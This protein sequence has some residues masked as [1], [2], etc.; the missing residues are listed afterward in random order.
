MPC[1]G[2][3]TAEEDARELQDASRAAC[4]LARALRKRFPKVWDELQDHLHPA[5]IEWVAEHDKAD[6]KREVEEKRE[7]ERRDLAQ[8]ARAKLSKREREALGIR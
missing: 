2:P 8:Q 6:R 7:R 4:N 3:D 5:T 1:L